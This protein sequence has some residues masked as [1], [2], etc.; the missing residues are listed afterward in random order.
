LPPIET[1]HRIVAD[2]DEKERRIAEM[3]SQISDAEAK[4]AAILDKYLK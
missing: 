1:Q 4:K 2:L 3:K